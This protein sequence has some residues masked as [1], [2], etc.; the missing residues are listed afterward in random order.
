MTAPRSIAVR[1]RDVRTVVASLAERFSPCCEC[2]RAWSKYVPGAPMRT[3][4]GVRSVYCD[5]H[6]PEG[7]VDSDHAGVARS[8][9]RL[10]VAA[11]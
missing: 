5:E 1:A 11:R 3:S 4:T 2:S 10:R 6:A 8:L 7:A 9:E